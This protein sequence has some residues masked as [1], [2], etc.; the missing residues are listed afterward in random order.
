MMGEAEC[1]HDQPRLSEHV[2]HVKGEG[3]LIRCE[4]LAQSR[5]YPRHHLELGGSRFTNDVRGSNQFAFDMVLTDKSPRGSYNQIM[6]RHTI[7]VVELNPLTQLLLY[8]YTMTRLP[9]FFGASGTPWT[10]HCTYIMVPPTTTG[11]R[12]LERMSSMAS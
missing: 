12:S 3:F 1:D 8:I 5:R 4:T 11:T 2:C 7:G 6:S 9:A 10:S